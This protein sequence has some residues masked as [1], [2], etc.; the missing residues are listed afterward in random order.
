MFEEFMVNTPPFVRWLVAVV[1]SVGVTVAFVKVFHQRALAFNGRDDVD[2]DARKARLRAAEKAAEAAGEPA[3][4]EPPLPP[5]MYNL[6]GRLLALTTTAFV[7]LLAFTFGNFWQNTKAANSATEAEAAYWVQAVVLS[8]PIPAEQ[9]GEQIKQALNSYRDSVDDT[10]WPMMQRGNA[11]DA[12]RTQL[13]DGV[14]LGKALLA[15]QEAGASSAPTWDS[16]ESAVTSM[17][18]QGRYRI[19]ALPGRAAPGAILVVFVLGVSTLVLTGIFQPSRLGANL[20]IMGIMAAI[21]ATLLFVLV[22]TSNPYT[23]TAGVSWPAPDQLSTATE[24]R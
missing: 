16:M 11:T 14:E 12:Y 3:P 5:A 20:A 21:V 17:L 7:F 9:G 22:E 19:D 18:E 6:S 13:F 10:Q 2:S 8:E 4:T 23:G 15:A 1:I 24:N